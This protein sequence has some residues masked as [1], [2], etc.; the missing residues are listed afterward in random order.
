MQDSDDRSN[1]LTRRGAMKVA[2][3]AV[4]AATISTTGAALAQSTEGSTATSQ[5]TRNALSAEGS[6]GLTH[7][8]AKTNGV[9]L[10]YV[11]T[12]RGPVVLC[13]T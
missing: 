2:G 10:H 3:A 11:K 5:E 6:V 1:N 13:N 4:T 8:R 9:N 7:K 12:G